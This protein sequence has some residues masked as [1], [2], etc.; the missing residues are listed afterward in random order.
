MCQ[1]H[2]GRLTGFW[3][4]LNWPKGWILMKWIYIYI[5][6]YIYNTLLRKVCT[7][8][9]KTNVLTKLGPLSFMKHD[10]TLVWLQE[11]RT[12]SGRC[13]KHIWD[14]KEFLK[15]WTLNIHSVLQVR[16]SQPTVRKTP[17]VRVR[18]VFDRGS[19][20]SLFGTHLINFVLWPG[21][22]KFIATSAYRVLQNFSSTL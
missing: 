21:F 4:L 22:F 20:Y 18:F 14:S 3:F 1:S 7:H 8:V 19:F 12:S 16:V 11:H 13:A 15:L 5:Y 9:C 6:I 17:A 2:T 10:D